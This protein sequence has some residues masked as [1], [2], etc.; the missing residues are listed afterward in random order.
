M[1]VRVHTLFLLTVLQIGPCLCAEEPV[2]TLLYPRPGMVH[3]LGMASVSVA[4]RPGS[5]DRVRVM[6]NGVERAAGE[7]RRDRA[8]FVVPLVGG[9]NE[10]GVQATLAGQVAGE[11]TAS[12]FRRSDLEAQ[13]R[14]VPEG[15]ERDRFHQRP[16]EACAACHSLST[17]AAGVKAAAGDGSTCLSCHKKL[18][19]GAWVHG[20][21]AV[22]SCLACHD[23]S[24]SPSFSVK[25]PIADVCFSC[26]QE[27]RDLWRSKK[28]MHGPV[29][30]GKCTICHGPHSSEIAFGLHK[31]TWY[32]CTTCHEDRGSGKHVLGH[33]FSTEGH[34]THGRPDPRR[35]GKEFTCASCHDPHASNVPQ[36][37]VI[38]AKST[39]ELCGLCHAK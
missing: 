31:A 39:F 17:A 15:F 24:A 3:E 9:R 35:P 26:H 36:M 8:C 7:V 34:P 5:A 16:N 10:I 25:E 20:P 18:A 6:V 27:Q 28:Y 21:V 38:D 32:L 11:E 37:W 33:S 29:T 12:V 4:L 23:P 1:P 30:T 19:V 22:G 2:I 13:Y 14:Q